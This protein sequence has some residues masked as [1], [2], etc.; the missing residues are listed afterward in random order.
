[1]GVGVGVVVGGCYEMIA[2]KA[3]QPHHF[4][5]CQT[6]YLVFFSVIKTF[7][8]RGFQRNKGRILNHKTNS[9]GLDLYLYSEENSF[10]ILLLGYD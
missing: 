8:S 2:K 4:R 5:L 10:Y 7:S 3:H 1:M 9:K 6:F